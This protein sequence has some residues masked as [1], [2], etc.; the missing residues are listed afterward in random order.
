MPPDQVMIM[1][2]TLLQQCPEC[3]DILIYHEQLRAE[4]KHDNDLW[5]IMVLHST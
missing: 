1:I 3:L 4:K 2:F 5:F